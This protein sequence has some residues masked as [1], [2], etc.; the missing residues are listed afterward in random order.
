M[1]TSAKDLSCFEEVILVFFVVIFWEAA[2]CF[3][4]NVAIGWSSGK[5]NVGFFIK[6]F[7]E[8][9]SEPSLGS[10]HHIS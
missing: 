6:A 2:G 10:G 3:I 7:R 4:F 9:A 5:S 8:G 1:A